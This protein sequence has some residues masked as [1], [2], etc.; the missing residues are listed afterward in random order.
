MSLT[1][2]WYIA[3]EWSA[4]CSKPQ[5][6]HLGF[7]HTQDL[8][9]HESGGDLFVQEPFDIRATIEDAISIQRVEAKRKGLTLEVVEDPQG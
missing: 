7:C 3:W 1:T 8:T 6:M 9:R 5:L 2:C 4:S